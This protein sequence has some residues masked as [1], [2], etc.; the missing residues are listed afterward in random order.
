MRSTDHPQDDLLIIEALYQY[1]NRIRDEDPHRSNRAWKLA[2][3]IADEHGLDVSD[4]LFQVEGANSEQVG[5]SVAIE[6]YEC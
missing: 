3:K 4:A 5:V 2:A 1:C 6:D